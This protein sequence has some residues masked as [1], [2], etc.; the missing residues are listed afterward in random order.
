MKAEHPVSSGSPSYRQHRQLGTMNQ[1]CAITCACR[2]QRRLQMRKIELSRLLLMQSSGEELTCWSMH[3][4]VAALTSPSMSLHQ[5]AGSATSRCM[6]ARQLLD[7]KGA[8]RSEVLWVVLATYWSP[9][10]HELDM[11]QASQTDVARAGAS[12][13]GETGAQ[14]QECH[15][16]DDR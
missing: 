8:C 4:E 10:K 16:G 2:K 15:Q 5:P 11:E 13:A 3:G 14:G 9:F 6:L 12:Q 1:P 7:M